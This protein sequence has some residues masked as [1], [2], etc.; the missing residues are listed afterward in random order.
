MNLNPVKFPQKCKE[1]CKNCP[2][3]VKNLASI[4]L[5]WYIYIFYREMN[6]IIVNESKP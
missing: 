6:L 5:L 3:L 1:F 4:L 2:F